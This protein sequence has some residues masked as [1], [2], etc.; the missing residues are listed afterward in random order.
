MEELKLH[1]TNFGEKWIKNYIPKY[2]S[3]KDFVS[4]HTTL[5]YNIH[6]SQNDKQTK[7]G[8]V[9]IQRNEWIVKEIITQI[10]IVI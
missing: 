7:A 6:T 5:E 1:L 10:M 9:K 3:Q 4:R 8:I 2:Q